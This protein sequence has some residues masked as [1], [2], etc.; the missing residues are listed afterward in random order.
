V[1]PASEGPLPR[2]P[3]PVYLCHRDV[4]YSVIRTAETARLDSM[5]A[6]P[7]KEGDD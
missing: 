5:W 2:I 4:F 6:L 1:T 7:T 3:L